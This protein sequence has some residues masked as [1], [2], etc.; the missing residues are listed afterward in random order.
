MAINL[1]ESIDSNDSSPL[2]RPF[3][4]SPLPIY[5]PS[6]HSWKGGWLWDKWVTVT[7]QPPPSHA[8]PHVWRE[9]YTAPARLFHL[10][11]LK[12]FPQTSLCHPR[13]THWCDGTGAS[14]GHDLAKGHV[15]TL[16]F[17]T[18]SICLCQTAMFCLLDS[19]SWNASSLSSAL[20][21]ISQHSIAVQA[22][23]K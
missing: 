14:P 10:S 18:S 12:A 2:S 20:Q 22:G 16:C 5:H 7:N 3:T 21:S 17:S 15:D 8:A 6:L 11:P 4:E 23:N 1:P 19:K 13:V 9:P